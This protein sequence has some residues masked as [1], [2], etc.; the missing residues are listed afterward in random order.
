MQSDF[1]KARKALEAAV[2]LIESDS[3][4]ITAL[5]CLNVTDGMVDVFR[6]KP[7]IL[8][9]QMNIKIVK[10]TNKINTALRA[11]DKIDMALYREATI[12]QLKDK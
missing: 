12:K 2:E 5:Q 1:K 10:I 11:M 8:I 3:D 7:V 6:E 9:N 4:T